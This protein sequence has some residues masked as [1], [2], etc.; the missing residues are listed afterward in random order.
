MNGMARIME[1]M[2]DWVDKAMPGSGREIF[3]L[4]VALYWIG[5]IGGIVFLL[6][7]NLR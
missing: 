4:S 6:I 5:M 7:A 2:A 1:A 3:Q